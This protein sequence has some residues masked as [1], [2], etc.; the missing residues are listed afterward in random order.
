V[1]ERGLVVVTSLAVIPIPAPLPLSRRT[2]REG[3]GDAEE[4]DLLPLE[5]VVRLHGA[6]GGALLERRLSGGV[7]G[8]GGGGGRQ[9]GRQAG[10]HFDV[11][12]D[13]HG[14]RFR[15]NEPAGV[16]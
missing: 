10:R 11:S 2:G 9:A 16:K 14:E 13:S 7:G 12:S 4:D 3:A 1:S 8:R 6:C 15:V 5:E